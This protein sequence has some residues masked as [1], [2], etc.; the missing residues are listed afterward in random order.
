MMRHW[1]GEV[2]LDLIGTPNLDS[3]LLI[4]QK[5]EHDILHN[6]K[7]RHQQWLLR[8]IIVK[9]IQLLF[10]NLALEKMS[11]TLIPLVSRFVIFS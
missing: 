4:K 11:A 7:H 3:T 2:E 6:L 8:A 10:T 1:G 9:Q 5:L